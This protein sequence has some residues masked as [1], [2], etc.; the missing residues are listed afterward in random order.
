MKPFTT[1]LISSVTA[2]NCYF[3]LDQARAAPPGGR[4]LYSRTRKTGKIILILEIYGATDCLDSV[5][6]SIGITLKITISNDSVYFKEC[7]RK[8]C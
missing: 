2:L 1:V 3:E 4:R 5:Q 8:W 6:S 7:D